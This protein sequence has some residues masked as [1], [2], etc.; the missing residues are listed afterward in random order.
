MELRNYQEKLVRDIYQ[1]WHQHR[2]IMAQLPTGGGKTVIFS[3]IAQSFLERGHGVLVLAHRQELISQAADKLAAI[4]PRP[5]GI[6][7]AGVRP[8]YSAPI[9]VASVQSAIRRL[10]KLPHPGLVVID[11]AHHAIAQTYRKILD[12]FPAAYQLGVS[13]T[14]C[15]T[16]GSGFND[17]FEAMVCGPSVRSLIEAGHLSQFRLFADPRPMTTKGAKTRQGDYSTGDVAALNPAIELSGNLVA[18]YRH[19]CP[20]KRCIVFAVNVEHSKTIAARYQAAGI[21][22]AHLDGNSSPDERQRTLAAFARGDL[23]VL[24]NVGLFTEG[25]DLPALDAVQIAR[26]TKSLALWLQMVGRA[27][28]PSPGKDQAVLIDHT[29]NWAIHGLPT[30]PRVWSLDGVEPEK[31]V[32]QRDRKSGEVSEGE[33]ST[34]IIEA[35]RVL[36]QVEDDALGEWDAVWSELLEIQKA[37]D[38]KA[39]WLWYRLQELRPPLEIWRRLAI[40]MGNKPGWAWYQFKKFSLTEDTAA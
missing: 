15:R 36:Q 28:R 11:E 21:P 5:A 18:S 12:N 29:K 39:S 16:D 1:Q 22:A 32:A 4:A 9:Q 2:R 30:R 23:L 19:H 38:Y 25:F 35:D 3:H 40:A 17:L 8:D 26:P 10:H 24:S 34:E 7:R 13:A 20:G 31:A 37:R 27:L 33:E 14:P 6:V